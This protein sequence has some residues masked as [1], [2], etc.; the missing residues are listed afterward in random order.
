MDRK[1]AFKHLRD[2]MVRGAL[3]L[4]PIWVTLVIVQIVY[5][6]CETWFGAATAQVVSLV[7]PQSWL[8]AIGATDGHIPGLSV[9]TALALLA[10]LGAI[11]SWH[12]GQRGLRLLDHLFLAIPGIKTV[13]AT[14]RSMLD[15]VGEPGKSR[16]QKVVFLDWAGPKTRTLGFVTNEVTDTAGKRFYY[17]FVP[18]VPNP[19][20]GF[21]MLV[22][23]EDVVV[24]DFTPEQGLKL[25][26]SLGVIAPGGVPPIPPKHC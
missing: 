1:T 18:T 13:Y 17:V 11:G 20:A 21:V 15:A 14:V 16:F 4:I 24:T 2:F 3:F 10:V 5:G 6:L 19:T 7:F 22:A 25:A 12:V 23:E 9:L 26:M 8:Q